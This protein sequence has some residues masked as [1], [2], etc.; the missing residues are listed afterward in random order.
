[1]GSKRCSKGKSC[2]GTCINRG[3]TCRIDLG[4]IILS[5]LR[6]VRDEIVSSS[7]P[8]TQ[9]TR[10]HSEDKVQELAL[11]IRLKRR[12][13]EDYSQEWGRL[14][15]LIDSLQG[16][17][18]RDATVKA[19]LA[20][21]KRLRVNVDHK[22]ESARDAQRAGRRVLEG[23]KPLGRTVEMINRY[24]NLFN[25]IAKR[26]DEDLSPDKMREISKKLMEINAK[27][28]RAEKRLEDIMAG[29]R[30]RL[31]QT[32]LTDK[33]VKDLV[34]RVW[35]PNTSE[36]TRAHMAEFVRMFN[37]RGFTDVEG[38]PGTMSIRSLSESGDRAYARI[39]KGIVKTNGEMTTTFHEIAHIVE[40]QRPWMS[41]FAV[42]WRDGKAF[43]NI[44]DIQS[45]LGRNV[46][47]QGSYKSGPTSSV[48]LV[49]LRDIFAGSNFDNSELAVVDNF[50]SN[51]MGKVYGSSTPWQQQVSTEVWSKAIENFTSPRT[52]AILYRRH[53]ELFEII[54]GMA[55]SP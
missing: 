19:N 18:K 46:P 32:N 17:A 34:S 7:P 35:T 55:V 44:Q 3:L 43:D 12:N 15:K 42:R 54:A 24:E 26:L 45:H 52:M 25:S 40:G 50:L 31:M 41:Q 20:V 36:E 27:R 30:E 33:Q 14:V 2:G 39:S 5:P 38:T 10:Q 4:P 9:L 6:K 1:M 47:S 21:G 16:D 11:K 22:A 48:P 29:V 49:K 28:S 8:T 23:F 53:P 51:Y 13:K 37:G